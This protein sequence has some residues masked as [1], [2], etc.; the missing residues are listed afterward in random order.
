M[1]RTREWVGEEREKERKLPVHNNA[2]V[3]VVATIVA[4]NYIH[5]SILK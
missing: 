1:R 3:S 5:S 4:Y 2:T